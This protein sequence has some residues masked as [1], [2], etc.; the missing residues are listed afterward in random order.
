MPPKHPPETNRF[1]LVLPP[2]PETIRF[3]SL[4]VPSRIPDG[5]NRHHLYWPKS[6]YQKSE[7]TAKF[8]E[9]RFNSV[10]ML[11]SAHQLIHKLYDGVPFP[12]CDVMKVYL[13]EATVLDELGVCIRSIEMINDALYE[14]NI[15]LKKA[16]TAER[17]NKLELV[18]KNMEA[19]NHFEI[20][21]SEVVSIAI[22][23]AI[24][25]LDLNAA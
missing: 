11:K 1:G 21:S 10:W 17:N 2:S 7:L 8:R 25:I 12:S 6:D 14:G 24:N 13:Q 22:N 16:S 23:R 5:V 4:N 9:H 3:R 18:N 19:I 15:S 20:L